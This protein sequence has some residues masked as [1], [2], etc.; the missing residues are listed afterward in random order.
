MRPEHGS[1]DDK[2]DDGPPLRA[3]DVPVRLRRD[4]MGPPSSLES[5]MF[6]GKLLIALLFFTALAVTEDRWL[7]ID[8][9]A[10]RWRMPP[11][12]LRDWR[13]RGYGPQAVRLG[14]GERGFFRYRLSDVERWERELERAQAAGGEA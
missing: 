3:G 14:R 4:Q 6:P 7:K 9:L 2:G 12:T 1:D 8:E 10:E 5:T 11:K 13:L